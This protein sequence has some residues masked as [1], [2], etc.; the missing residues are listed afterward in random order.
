[1]LVA[2]EF[3]G[4]VRDAFIA[5]GHNAIS[6]DI[7]PSELP[8]PHYQGDVRDILLES[9]D[10]RICFPPC[11][12]LCASGARWW[13]ERRAEQEKAIEFFLMFTRLPGRWAIENPVGIMSRKYRKPDQIIQPWMFGHGEWKT[14]CLWLKGLPPLWSTDIAQGNERR[15][16]R[17]SEHANRGRE[18][19]RTYTGIAAAMA[20]Q[21]GGF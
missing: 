19:S 12:Y 1:M 10:V 18:R 2:C 7:I 16:H 21:W 3:S 20:E 6:C 14:T 13:K 5:R 9:W 17:M 15:I 4:A 8:G 11:T